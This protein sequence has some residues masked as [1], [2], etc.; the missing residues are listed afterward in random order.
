VIIHLDCGG[1]VPLAAT[2]SDSSISSYCS[3]ATP[4]HD[5]ETQ[6]SRGKEE[7]RGQEAEGDVCLELGAGALACDAVPAPDA[8][9]VHGSDEINEKA[10]CDHPKDEEDKVDWPVHKAPGKRD[11]EYEREE[12]GKSGDD[13]GIDKAL[14]APV[15]DASD[16]ME[17]PAS[18]S[19]NSGRE[20]QL[21]HAEE[22]GKDI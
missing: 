16:L 8:A 7:N 22:E 3:S 15:R 11:Q 5:V 12:N 1:A 13:F 18:D 21:A 17:V 20:G 4:V 9:A 6:E 2:S 14:L 19:C 10:K